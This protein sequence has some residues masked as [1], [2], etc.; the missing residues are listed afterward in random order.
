MNRTFHIGQL[1]LLSLGRHGKVCGVRGHGKYRW[2][3]VQL[4]TKVLW[5]PAAEVK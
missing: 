4:A 1:V 5:A 3:C 2:V